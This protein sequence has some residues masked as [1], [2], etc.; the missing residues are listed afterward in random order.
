MLDEGEKTSSTSDLGRAPRGTGGLGYATA[1]DEL[2]A[3]T[4]V[5]DGGG[6]WTSTAPEY[7]TPGFGVWVG[8]VDDAAA[9][10]SNFSLIS[11][12]K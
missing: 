2:V 6:V 4:V 9:S 7:R 3:S 12:M 10:I 5:V 1:S 11:W 8:F